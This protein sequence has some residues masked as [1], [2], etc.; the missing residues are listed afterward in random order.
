M[1]TRA[2]YSIIF[3]HAVHLSCVMETGLWLPQSIA[4]ALHLINADYLGEINALNEFW[5]FVLELDGYGLSGNHS[6]YSNSINR[7]NITCLQN[8]RL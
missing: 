3:Y 1:S 5:L 2:E 6:L 7:I 8:V 4:I